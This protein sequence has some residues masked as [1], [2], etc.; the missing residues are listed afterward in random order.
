M[1]IAGY[2][3]EKQPILY[4]TFSNALKN[5]TVTHSYLIIGEAGTP[6]LETATYLAKSLLCDHPDP[7]ADETC[8]TCERVDQGAYP[9]FLLLDGSKQSIK[10]DDV[11]DLVSDFQRTPLEH[12]GIMI[13]VVNLVENMTVEAVNSLLKFLEEPSPNTFAF[14]TTRNESKIL[15]TI[16]SR[17]QSLRLRL[18]PRQQ[19]I[20]EAIEDGVQQDDAELLSYFYNNAELIKKESATVE[21]SNAKNA[22]GA[23]IEGLN[24][25]PSYARFAIEREVIPLIVDKP[26]ARYYF[27]MMSLFFQELAKVKAGDDINLASYANILGELAAKLPHIEESLLE[28]MSLKGDIELNVNMALLLSHLVNTITKE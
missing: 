21:Y 4:R 7:L 23:T 14:L 2:L 15:P 27:D 10:K 24:T 9:D 16:V 17:C 8:I 13:Y 12:K 18:L 28:I 3:K 20:A 1:K 19:I 5:N 11:V 6:L 26:S 22:L 25:N